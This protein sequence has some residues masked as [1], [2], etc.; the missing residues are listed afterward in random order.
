[1]KATDV[2]QALGGRDIPVLASTITGLR[3]LM[4]TEDRIT[5][6]D[7]SRVVL[8]DP[9]LTLKTLRFA[10]QRRTERQSADITT[11]EH[12]VLMHGITNFLKSFSNLTSLESLLAKDPLALDGA[13]RVV[14]RAQHAAAFARAIARQRHD[15]ESDEVI[16][17]ALLHDLAEL[18]L[19]FHM[20]RQEAEVRFLVDHAA[21]LR[22]ASAQRA[23]L[24]FTHVELQLALARTWRLPDLLCRLMDDD[25]ADHPRVINVMTATALAR[26]LNHGW[27]DPALPD[28]YAKLE[29]VLGMAPD[30]VQRMVRNA[31]LTA[32]RTWLDTGVRPVAT[33]L[34]MQ[35]SRIVPE[36]PAFRRAGGIDLE[37]F[38]HA[39]ARLE[40]QEHGMDNDAAIVWA[41]YAL[42]FGLGL[43]RVMYANVVPSL[44]TLRPRFVLADTP[45]PSPWQQLQIPLS[46]RDFFPRL[47]AKQQGL[48]AGGA[49][50]EKLASL[51]LPEQRAVLGEGDF[52]AMSLFAEGNALGAVVADR[53][54]DRGDI[55]DAMYAPF[56]AM[57]VALGH[58]LSLNAHVHHTT[59]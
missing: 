6:R 44:N 50:R 10:E 2:V 31:S 21:G 55:A 17:G 58:R 1:M 25:H 56:K 48:W 23:V 18:M 57:C 3:A 11:V 38:R 42:Q 24:G 4:R 47:L 19:W 52:L 51:L 39:L 35:A 20:P 12:A 54:Q 8:R 15:I 36:S 16:I 45:L 43:H 7:V 32:A 5:P 26:H 30:A 9:M 34:P 46:G 27:D 37:F 53:G 59:A 33:W 29:K 41:L 14:S 22:S 28:D 40:D 49:N 13:L